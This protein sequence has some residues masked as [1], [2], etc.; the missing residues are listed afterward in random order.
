RSK[1]SRSITARLVP[2]S[3]TMLTTGT[4]DEPGGDLSTHA[5][6]VVIA[7]YAVV[8]IVAAAVALRRRDA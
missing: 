6:F 3:S 8:P 4:T 2:T 1:I 5:S 7:A